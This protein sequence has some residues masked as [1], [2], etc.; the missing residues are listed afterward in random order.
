MAQLS[1]GDLCGPRPHQAGISA[2]VVN[3]IHQ[4]NVEF[5]TAN[6]DASDADAVHC[7]GYIPEDV[8]DSAPNFRFLTV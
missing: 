1:L 6:A 2:D 7:S 3:Q 5:R 8:F 4:P